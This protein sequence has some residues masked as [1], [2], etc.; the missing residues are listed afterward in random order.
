MIGILRGVQNALTDGDLGGTV[1]LE[2]HGCVLALSVGAIFSFWPKVL[3]KT[4]GGPNF[5]FCAEST[6]EVFKIATYVIITYRP[7]KM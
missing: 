7:R 4:R 5:Q 6:F 3:F 2:A 1:A